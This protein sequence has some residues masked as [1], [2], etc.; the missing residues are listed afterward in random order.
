MFL[1]IIKCFK[2]KWLLYYGC[3]VKIIYKN[4]FPVNVNWS[5]VNFFLRMK[6][7][8]HSN[9]LMYANIFISKNIISNL[10]G[11]NCFLNWS[12]IVTINTVVRLNDLL[13][14]IVDFFWQKIA[15]KDL[16]EMN[17]SKNIQLRKK[18]PLELKLF[19]LKYNKNLFTYGERFTWWDQDNNYDSGEVNE[20]F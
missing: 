16:I 6:V 15:K 12:R 13:N 18:R 14:D 8:R 9:L 11:I 4:I 17:F 2:L 7:H 5:K 19:N 1:L 10:L 20:H 3:F